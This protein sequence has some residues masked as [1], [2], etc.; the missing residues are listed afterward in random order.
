MLDPALA[1]LYAEGMPDDEV[2]VIIRLADPVTIP[3]GVRIITRFGHIVTCRLQ[4]GDI[5]RVWD[6]GAVLSM[7][8][9]RIYDPTPAYID[10]EKSSPPEISVAESDQFALNP[11]CRSQRRPDGIRAT[12]TGIVI[13][14]IDWGVDFAHPDFRREDGRTRLLALW[15]QSSPYDSRQ[16]NPYGYGKTHYAD[17]I[18][19][20][21]AAPNPYT[22][23]GYDPALSDAGS[24]S[25]GTHTLSISAGNGR[26][27]GPIGLAP[28]ARLVFV[29]LSTYTA[30]GPTPLGDSVALLEGLDFI[31]KIAG[32]SPLCIN[33]SLGRQAGQHDSK[34]LTERA[35]DFFLLEEPGRA[36]IQ[37]AGNYL[38]RSIHT[39]GT[40]RPGEFRT[41][42]IIIN[43]ADR[44]PNEVDLWYSGLDRFQIVLHGPGETFEVRA[45]PEEQ[46][47]IVVDGKEVGH[48]YH[49]IN[50]PNNGDNQVTLFLYRAAPPGEWELE[51][52]AEDVAD[53]RFHA[54]I[55]RD[56]GCRGC[57]AR[58]APE[59]DDPTSTLGTICTGLR[60]LA[61]GAYD[62]R[63]EERPL[64]PFSSSGLTRDGRQK[65]DLVAPGVRELAARSRPRS[66]EPNFPQLTHMSGT[67]MAAPYVTGT[68][69]LMFEAAG[70]PLSIA[71]TRRMLLANT[72]PPPSDASPADLLRLGSGYLNTA[73]AV[74]EAE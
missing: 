17:A 2:A 62:A 9:P 54:W 44:T 50:D 26:G 68:I 65:P 15:D 25:H 36:I 46:K 53:G 31:A 48:L 12:G 52:F 8:R 38:N 14:H 6:Q 7:K 11:E 55:E 42:R 43:E 16:P 34:T 45:G 39:R 56:A 51:L 1:E 29:H 3:S 37:S 47:A 18:D 57:Q 60:T 72:D 32:T 28:D 58:F 13:A 5:P 22:A 71:E 4:R 69:A 27:G 70:R 21:L 61:V 23:L 67:S 49:R 10:E 74:A 41:L 63:Q 20:A 19:K 24:G 59:D 73:A 40:L 33:A 30:E 35:M 64:A 66:E